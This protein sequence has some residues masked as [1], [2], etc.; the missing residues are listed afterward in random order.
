MSTAYPLLAT[1]FHVPPARPNLVPRSRLTAHLSEGL[2]RS[3]TLISAPAGFGKTTL[4]SEWCASETGRGFPLAW[5]SL[6]NDDNDPSRFLTYLAAALGTLKPGLGE[7]A[8]ALL[9]ASRPQPPP[10]QIILTSL[11]NDLDG[12]DAS[13]ALVL[14]DYHVITAQPIH[15]ALTF[16]LDHLPR[17]MHLVL[18]TRADPFGLPLARL[19]ARHQLV[20][21][22]ADDLRFTS[23]EAAAFLNQVMGLALSASDVMAL[24]QRIEGWIAGLQLAALAMQGQ[25]DI[26][27]FIAAFSGS[28]RYIADY[29]VDEVLNRQSE[30]VQ[31]F[32]LQT[33]ILDQLCG[34]LCEAVTI[35]PNAQAMLEELELANLFVVPLDHDRH[36]YRYHHLFAEALRTRLHETYPG[37]LPDLHRQAA[38]WHEQH[39]FVPEAVS[40]A[41]AAG[42]QERAAR[43]VEQNAMAMLRRGEVMTLLNW[44]KA[45]ERPGHIRP[46]LC[47]SEAWALTITGQ[48]DRAE[49]LL[50]AAEQSL[51]TA[52]EAIKARDMLGHIAAI[53]AYMAVRRG[54]TLH[55]IDL[56][57]QALE[58][59]SESNV[60]VHSVVRSMLG[61]ACWV[62]GDLAGASRAFAEASRLGKVAGNINV[63][64]PALCALASLRMLKG[65]L[66]QAMGDYQE[67]LQLAAAPRGQFLPPAAAACMG[68]G[69]L[70]CEWNDLEGAAHQLQKSADLSE[71]LGHTDTRVEAHISLSRLQQ[72]Q[73]DLN[74]AL[75]L[76]QRAERIAR[77]STLT[78][79]TD[80]LL[81]AHQ[82]RLW[83]ARGDPESAARLAQERGL[84]VEDADNSMREPEH[85]MLVH[86]LLAQGDVRAALTWLEGL[87]Q[88]AEQG[89]RRGRVIELLILKALAH[90]V[91][92]DIPQAL[93]SL[94]RA[95]SLAQPEGYV[96]LFLDE[97]AP[98]AELLRHAGSHGIAP[99]YVAKL[100]SEFNKDAGAT[101]AAQ[102]PLIEPLTERE[103]EVLCLMADGLTNQLIAKK[104][105]VAMGTV[106]A[107]T[108]S[109]YR[110]LDVTN[111]TQAVARARE[112]GL[113]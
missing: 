26:S 13:F 63:A 77:G 4:V 33:S 92:G 85:L 98:M 11:I 56:A 97:G 7:T 38:E 12:L 87:L 74:G 112:L 89:E 59:L 51:P 82:M 90:R 61:D 79:W 44:L 83:L 71:L 23:H 49:P 39:G 73:G 34:A 67:A 100:L 31:A 52:V 28:N 102:Q 76:L 32:L 69:N 18:L 72:A 62:N 53:R 101:P 19:R 29:L 75:D 111:R 21:L 41:L 17:Q 15:E 78:P 91:K 5:L 36:W 70:L 64:V 54:D 46:W 99:K 10:P 109:L 66:H 3:L 50:K 86:L 8:L 6:D 20:D 40:H 30:T 113:L 81:T 93:K 24:E 94:E 16:I 84:V 1:K 106:K 68:I 95:L 108:A 104:L 103:L 42:D 58:Y 37:C 105:V 96:R 107:H 43:L 110:K 35:Q 65:E 80:S 48:P 27:G 22:R 2:T 45:V 57:Q 47:L 55:T 9:H 88:S 25:H 14:D 60:S